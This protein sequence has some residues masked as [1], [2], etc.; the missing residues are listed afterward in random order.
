MRQYIDIITEAANMTEQRP[1]LTADQFE[2]GLPVAY[3]DHYLGT[4]EA[5]DPTLRQRQ[6]VIRDISFYNADGAK[7]GAHDPEG[8][9]IASVAWDN[10]RGIDPQDQGRGVHYLNLTAR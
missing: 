9:T 10:G 1:S 8:V 5:R 2:P 6:G 7:C 3:S 4:H